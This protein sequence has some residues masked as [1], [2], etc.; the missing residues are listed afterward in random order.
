[1]ETFS[2]KGN[3]FTPSIFQAAEQI[4][5]VNFSASPTEVKKTDFKEIWCK[6]PTVCRFLECLNT[7]VIILQ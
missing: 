3:I 5:V 2:N 7:F 4:P 6:T 1:M